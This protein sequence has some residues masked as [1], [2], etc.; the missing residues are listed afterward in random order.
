M[1]GRAP[2]GHNVKTAIDGK[3][4]NLTSTSNITT[5]TVSATS[6]T[7]TGS[8]T[9]T[10][11]LATG[12]VL[13][14]TGYPNV[15]TALDGKQPTLTGTSNIT[16]G[17]ISATS[18]IL[19]IAGYSNVRTALDG[20]QGTLTTTTDVSV[21]RV[22]VGDGS[23]TSPSISFN[24]STGTGLVREVAGSTGTVVDGTKLFHFTTGATYLDRGDQCAC[25]AHR[26]RIACGWTGA[27]HDAGVVHR[28]RYGRHMQGRCCVCTARMLLWCTER[29]MTDAVWWPALRCT[30]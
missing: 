8:I 2:R 15:S 1:A 10:G 12:G 13:N 18:G 4:N 30:L 26:T 23:V 5:G 27:Q 11:N 22:T 17:T 9:A 14:I 6:V 25:P 21:R 16:T 20:K 28:A 7:T 3:Q 24:S 19:N 29:G